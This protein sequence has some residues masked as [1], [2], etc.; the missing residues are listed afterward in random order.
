MTDSY[1]ADAAELDESNALD[2]I[3]LYAL[4]EAMDKL[5]QSGQLEP[6]TVIL[7]GE[8]LH[9]ESYPGEEVVEC[10]NAATAAVGLLAHVMDAYAFAYD[11]YLNTDEGTRDAIIVER[12]KPGNDEA[13]A[14]ALLYTL[15][16]SDEGSLTFEE[17]LY[18]LGPAASLL[19]GNTLTSDDL[20]EL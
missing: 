2:K 1:T 7:H 10:F 4:D 5:E 12:G 18:D 8:N 14:F 13:E 3:V 16:E 20:D 6:F 9:V 19:Q 11:G 15:D 17:G